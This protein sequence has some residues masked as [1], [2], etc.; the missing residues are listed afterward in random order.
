MSRVLS[1]LNSVPFFQ[2]G[3][4]DGDDL[5]TRIKEDLGG[6]WNPVLQAGF[7]YL[8]TEEGY[9]YGSKSYSSFTTSVT[10]AAESR[11]FNV[12]DVT[13]NGPV[14]LR[15]QDTTV[16]ITRVS[17]PL[18][19]FVA[20]SSWSTSGAY[21]Y[22]TVSGALVSVCSDALSGMYRA[23]AS[24]E[25][26]YT[27]DEYYYNEVS[28]RVYIRNTGS[29]T[30]YITT[31]LPEANQ[32]TPLLQKEIHRVDSDNLVRVQIPVHPASG[33]VPIIKK[34]TSAGVVTVTGTVVSGNV[35][36]LSGATIV[37]G[38]VVSVQYT[39]K[40][41]FAC[42]PSGAGVAVFSAVTTSGRYFFEYETNSEERYNTRDL[43]DW[44]RNRLELNPLL[45]RV[46]SGFLYLVDQ[47]EPY[48]DPSELTIFTSNTHPIVFQELDTTGQTTP[49]S[50][51]TNESVLVR[52]LIRD[53]EGN[54]LPNERVSLS[55]TGAPCSIERAYG[56]DDITGWR[57]DILYRV[58]P[59]ASGAIVLTSYAGSGTPSGSI[60]ITPYDVRTYDDEAEYALGKLLLTIEETPYREGRY[61]VSAYYC[62]PDGAPWQPNLSTE[63]VK[64]AVT[65]TS[66]RSKFY[67]ILG[68][69]LGSTASTTVGQDGVAT[70]LIDKFPGDRIQASLVTPEGRT[71]LSRPI[72]ITRK[73][74]VF[75]DSMVGLKAT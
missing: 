35:I 1:T 58:T 40:D 31:L 69:D 60:T 43:P 39:G 24:A 53:A 45:D 5:L 66:S 36:Q 21:K 73:P 63:E 28:N 65:F 41:T 27:T 12:G 59:F 62:M 26:I 67:S 6:G 47:D 20:V 3:I 25:D 70:L 72:D 16:S 48:P 38:D 15:L 54:L 4:G 13:D 44:N 56:E 52:I 71:R 51:Y 17:S 9:L 49:T 57:G 46:E 50:G 75:S 61:R 23:V 32:T 29:P 68:E 74:P 2:S 22:T 11:F 8:G 33:L 7:Y 14:G 42:V 34:P 30:L 55:S 10:N 19:P 64:T 18:S 37:S